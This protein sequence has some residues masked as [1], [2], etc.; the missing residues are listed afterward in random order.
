MQEISAASNEQNSGANQINKAI[1]QL[2]QVTQ[3]N[4]ATADEMA[5]TSDTLAQQAE[6]LRKTITF[7]EVAQDTRADKPEQ[8][9]IPKD[10]RR[11]AVIAAGMTAAKPVK[12]TKPSVHQP[13]VQFGHTE[14]DIEDHHDLDFEKY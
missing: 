3:Q 8:Q 1:Q 12:T 4:T 5:S 13:V 9:A 10:P 7:F 2:D 6:Q 14:D 11:K